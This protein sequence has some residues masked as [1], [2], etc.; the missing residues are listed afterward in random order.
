VVGRANL[1]SPSGTASGWR[2]FF[3]SCSGRRH[4][5]FSHGKRDHDNLFAENIA[6]EN[7]FNRTYP[8]LPAGSQALALLVTGDRAVFLR[9]S[10]NWDPTQNR[11]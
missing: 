3:R 9:G 11:K 4:S 10:D 2:E 5:S 6:F 8:Q 1:P 7:D